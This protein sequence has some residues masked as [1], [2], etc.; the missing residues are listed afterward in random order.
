MIYFGKHKIGY[1]I[2]DNFYILIVAFGGLLALLI[3]IF[4]FYK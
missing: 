2:A 3:L 1:W 4:S